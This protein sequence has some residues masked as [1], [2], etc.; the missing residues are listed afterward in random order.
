L[1]YGEAMSEAKPYAGVAEFFAAASRSGWSIFVISHRTR[2]PYLGPPHDLHAAA[3]EWLAANGLTG[4]SVGCLSET[5]VFL[6]ESLDDKLQRIAREHCDM[7]V[8]DLPEL[9][10]HP[11]F[12][13]E[14]QRICFDPANRCAE[15]ELHRVAA[16]REL[17]ARWFGGE[18]A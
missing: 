1:V 17:T 13:S 16:W 11:D 6:E 2:Q 5:N 15:P 9:L 3:R 4:S 18:D 10:L 12:P 8:D 14:T 7:F